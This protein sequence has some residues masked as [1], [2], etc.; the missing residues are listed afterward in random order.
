MRGWGDRGRMRR[1]G[2]RGEGRGEGEGRGG[3]RDGGAR[4]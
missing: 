3:V 1:V 4:E 2:G